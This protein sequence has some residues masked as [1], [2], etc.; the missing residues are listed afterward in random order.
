MFI[1]NNNARIWTSQNEVCIN[2]THASVD[3]THMHRLVGTHEEP[4]HR[5]WRDL[6]PGIQ[7]CMYWAPTR[8][9]PRCIRAR[10]DQS[11]ELLR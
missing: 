5:P 9:R 2:N 7:S 6:G 3:Q 10:R 8:A 11:S 4:A 1:G